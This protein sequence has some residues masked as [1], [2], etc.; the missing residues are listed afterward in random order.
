MYG[1]ITDCAGLGTAF[2]VNPVVQVYVQQ[3][4]L[5]TFFARIFSLIPGGNFFEFRRERYR[6]GGGI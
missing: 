3:A 5:P 6:G 2:A 1:A 4:K